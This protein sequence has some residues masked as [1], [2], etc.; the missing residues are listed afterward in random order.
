MNPT[1][2]LPCAKEQPQEAQGAASVQSP[3]CSS[4]TRASL[5]ASCI[6]WPGQ[7]HAV[8]WV[9]P[10]KCGC[11]GQW[12]WEN[13]CSLELLPACLAHSHHPAA[14][15][16]PV[17]VGASFLLVCVRQGKVFA[18]PGRAGGSWWDRGGS[19]VLVLTL[20]GLCRM[21]HAMF[22]PSCMAQGW[23]WCHRGVLCCSPEAGDA[24][25]VHPCAE[26]HR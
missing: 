2:G 3:P 4:R 18:D 13:P 12:D 21:Q 14:A 25:P 24:A 9:L 1:E 15:A 19:G 20:G 7:Q 8:S 16:S 6:L 10:D 23:L 5:L 26:V 22:R 17:T 11:D